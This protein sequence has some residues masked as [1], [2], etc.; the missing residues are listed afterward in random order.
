MKT[1]KRSECAV[2]P[3]VLKGKWFDMIKRGEK[4]EEYRDDTPYWTKR[5]RL[6]NERFWK[7][8]NAGSEESRIV[9]FRWGYSGKAPRMAFRVPEIIFT[10]FCCSPRGQRV[11]WGEPKW[12][13][14]VICLG[15]R[16][17][18][19]DAPDGAGAAKQGCCGKGAGKTTKRRNDEARKE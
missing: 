17:K 6:W 19:V 12:P 14:W 16:V 18:L 1:L 15:E 2:L 11:E 7:L 13:H 4:R 3:L 8:R 10:R 5:I 9:E